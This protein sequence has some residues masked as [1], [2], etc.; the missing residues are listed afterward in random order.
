[1]LTQTLLDVSEPYRCR[2][3]SARNSKDLLVGRLDEYTA[4]GAFF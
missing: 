3:G 1:M 2:A 4:Q